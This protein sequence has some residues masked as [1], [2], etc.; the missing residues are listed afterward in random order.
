[1]GSGRATYSSLTASRAAEVD[2]VGSGRA[3]DSSLT[4]SQRPRW[5]PW[6][7]ARL[8]LLPR[9]LSSGRVGRRGE[10]TRLRFL[11]HR[12]SSGRGGRR[13][14]RRASDSSRAR[15]RRYSTSAPP[16][17]ARSF[18]RPLETHA[19]AARPRS[20]GP[21]RAASGHGHEIDEAK[22][23]AGPPAPLARSSTRR[24]RSRGHR[25]RSRC[26]DAAHKPS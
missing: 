22:V 1:M 15:G 14:E 4:A 17:P 11:P 24:R 3:S 13:G 12:L 5:M 2:A 23:L 6:E 10:R 21:R 19:R 18:E 9:R 8:R 26:A 16:T 20:V 25:R 7:R